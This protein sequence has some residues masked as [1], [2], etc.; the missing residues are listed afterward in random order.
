LSGWKL[1]LETD[2]PSRRAVAAR[3]HHLRRALQ[4]GAIGMLEQ[5]IIEKLLSMRLRGMADALKAWEQDPGVRELS[6]I[7]HLSLLVDQQWNWRE[8]QAR[9]RRLNS[10]SSVTTH[11]SETSTAGPLVD[12]R[13]HPECL[14]YWPLCHVIQR[15]LG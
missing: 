8:N 1:P 7:E 12:W 2:V 10:Q 6:F 15:T 14:R 4:I 5:P 13:R 3:K 11:V 9:A